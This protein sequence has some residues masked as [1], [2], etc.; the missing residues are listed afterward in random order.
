MNLVVD[1]YEYVMFLIQKIHE[2]IVAIL[3]FT[4]ETVFYWIDQSKL[5]CAPPMLRVH[6][7]IFPDFLLML[8]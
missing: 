5:Y 6:L 4:I 3:V 2:T 7:I 1:Y 8:I